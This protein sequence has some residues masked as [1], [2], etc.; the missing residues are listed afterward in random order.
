M[1]KLS[2]IILGWY[3]WM[4]NRNNEL[5]RKRLAICVKCELMKWGVCTGCGCPLQAK[6]RIEGEVC[7]HPDG[8]KWAPWKSCVSGWTITKSYQEDKCD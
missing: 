7:P 6:S 2:R 4:T 5:A 8:D 3:Y 1:K